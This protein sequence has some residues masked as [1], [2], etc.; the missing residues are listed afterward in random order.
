M[1]GLSA[2]YCLRTLRVSSNDCDRARFEMCQSRFTAIQV[3]CYYYY[4]YYYHAAT[5]G[6]SLTCA[7]SYYTC[8]RSDVG[9]GLF[10]LTIIRTGRHTVVSCSMT[11]LPGCSSIVIQPCVSA[12][13]AN[14]AG[15]EL[16]HEFLTSSG[17][18]AVNCRECVC[19]RQ[20]MSGIKL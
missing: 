20:M 5:L 8:R 3:H 14:T 19:V 4:Y 11:R 7:H 2:C 6:F 16:T 9:T 15:K 12:T 10:C 13:P 17:V 1:R 18:D